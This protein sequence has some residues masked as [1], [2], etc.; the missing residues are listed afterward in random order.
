VN[1]VELTL[2]ADPDTVDSEEGYSHL[3]DVNDELLIAFFSCDSETSARAGSSGVGRSWLGSNRDA[4]HRP[5]DRSDASLSTS[6]IHKTSP[7]FA[8]CPSCTVPSYWLYHSAFHGADQ[9][10]QSSYVLV[11]KAEM[12]GGKAVRKYHLMTSHLVMT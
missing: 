1:T 5:S 6:M 12:P 10:Y 8:T 3:V 2:I 4:D 9:R 11:D 7:T